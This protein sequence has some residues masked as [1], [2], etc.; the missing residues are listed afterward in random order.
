M[1]GPQCVAEVADGL[2]VRT[3]LPS[4]TTALDTRLMSTMLAR[5]HLLGTGFALIPDDAAAPVQPL[6]QYHLGTKVSLESATNLKPFG[7]RK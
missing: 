7:F 6:V 1:G 5:L 2:G 3:S 4:W